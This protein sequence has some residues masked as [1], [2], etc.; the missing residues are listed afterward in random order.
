MCKW[1]LDHG[2][3]KKW[4]EN[5]KNYAR[6][7]LD[8]QERA[9]RL[10]RFLQMTEI[11][12]ATLNER[13]Y[14]KIEE[15]PDAIFELAPIL[16]DHAKKAIS[17]QVMPVEDYKKIIKLA[18]PIVRFPCACRRR[19]LG[20]E[21]ARYC[22]GFGRFTEIIGQYP[23]YNR[24]DLDVLT[25][26]E[27]MELVEKWNKMGHVFTVHACGMPYIGITCSCQYPACSVLRWRV[28]YGDF[29]NFEFRKAE[30]YARVDT[31]AC[32][33]CG[34]CLER[35]IFGAMRLDRVMKTVVVDPRK[36]Y[37]CG[38][39]RLNC[40]Y[41]ALWLAPR[42]Q[43]PVLVDDGELDKV[44]I[45]EYGLVMPKTKV[46]ITIDYTKCTDPM[47][48]AK[49]QKVCAASVFVQKPLY[50]RE[51]NGP[52]VPSKNNW[53]L[54]PTEERFCT[55][56]MDCVKVCPENAI[57]IRVKELAKADSLLGGVSGA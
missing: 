41:D 43:N 45:P 48:C 6:E 52:V 5:M 23:D 49:C 40:E 26:E 17:A 53:Q 2:E 24:G 14:H 12:S 56:C 3:G 4:Y 42:E 13:I 18:N 7:M 54:V 57:T 55:Y 8:D 30:Y 1:C 31:E 20:D 35:C 15:N 46:E 32:T 11:N 51:R 28:R 38:Q 27:T 25:Q 50:I 21:N 19:Y 22:I 10:H 34:K 16:E 44:V 29:Y 47:N 36:C 9:E 33:A 37:G 39:C